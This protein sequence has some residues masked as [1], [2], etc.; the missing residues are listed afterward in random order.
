MHDKWLSGIL[1]Y[2]SGNVLHSE[3]RWRSDSHQYPRGGIQDP[4]EARGKG[5]I[6]EGFGQSCPRTL[7]VRANTR[8]L[9]RNNLFKKVSA[10]CLRLGLFAPA[11]LPKGFGS[12]LST[13]SFG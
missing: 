7:D 8:R 4:H 5:R 13:A 6:A 3:N 10:E 11:L 9:S 1:A 12:C 2:I